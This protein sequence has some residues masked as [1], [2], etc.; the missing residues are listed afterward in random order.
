[1]TSLAHT[2]L[3]AGCSRCFRRRSIVKLL[4]RVRS[5]PAFLPMQLTTSETTRNG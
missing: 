2:T 3:D 5:S 4:T 1:M